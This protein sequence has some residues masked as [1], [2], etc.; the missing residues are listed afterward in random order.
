MRPAGSRGYKLPARFRTEAIRKRRRHPFG[1][2]PGA[3]GAFWCGGRGVAAG[4]VSGGA[5]RGAVGQTGKHD[6]PAD[7]GLIRASLGRP[8][9]ALHGRASGV[10]V[11]LPVTVPTSR[12][13]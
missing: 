10:A 7:L 6:G 5:G 8:F 13:M 9:A 3:P 2:G 4:Q 12:E 1:R 11:W